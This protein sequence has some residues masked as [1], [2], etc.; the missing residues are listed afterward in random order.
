MFTPLSM[1][2]VRRFPS[3]NMRA[4]WLLLQLRHLRWAT[5]TAGKAHQANWQEDGRFQHSG[6]RM[7]RQLRLGQAPAWPQQRHSA[8]LER[9]HSLRCSI[10]GLS[11]C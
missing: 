4:G 5:L 2:Q 6:M 3:A 1:L 11:R 7:H 9:R 8:A 10:P